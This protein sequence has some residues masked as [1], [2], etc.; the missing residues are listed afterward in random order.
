MELNETWQRSA[1]REVWEETGLVINDADIKVFDVASSVEG[2]V[3]LVFGEAPRIEI[4]QAEFDAYTGSNETSERVVLR[5]S[6]DVVFP[7]HA[8]M[9]DRW[10]QHTQADV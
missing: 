7:L 6:A 8:K 2:G 10:L 5:S 3:L 9:I 4:T 1:A